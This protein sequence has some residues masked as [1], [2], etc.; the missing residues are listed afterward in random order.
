[1]LFY[2]ETRNKNNLI[3]CLKKIYE[4][5]IIK[6]TIQQIKEAIHLTQSSVMF[7]I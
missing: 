7:M 3:D 2:L 1:M 4:L 5:G 6:K